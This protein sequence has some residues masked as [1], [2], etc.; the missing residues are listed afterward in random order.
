MLKDIVVVGGGPAGMM[1]AIR[2]SQLR[3]TVTLVEK[4][5]ACGLKLLLSGKGRCN[6]TNSCDLESFL[7]RYSA[8]GDFLRDSFKKFFNLEL[9]K[10]FEQRGLPLVI[11]RQGRVFPSTN[12]SDSVLD[13]LKKEMSK[14]KVKIIYNT[15]VKQVLRSDRP[16]TKPVVRGLVCSGSQVIEADKIVLAT[17]GLSYQSTGSNGDGYKMAAELGHKVV[18]P[19]PGLIALT[20]NFAYLKILQGLTLKNVGLNFIGKAVSLRT[21][22]GE[23]LFTDFGVSGPLVLTYSGKVLDAGC[24]SLQIDLKP[25]LSE[26]QTRNRIIREIKK[27]PGKA[28]KNILKELVPQK[29]AG[30]FPLLAEI[31]PDK[32]GGNITAGERDSIVSLFKK[33]PLQITGSRP[34]NEALVTRGGVSLKEINPRTMESRLVRGLF[35]AGELIDLDADTGGYNLQQAFSTGYLAGESAAVSENE[36]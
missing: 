7:K 34:I 25:G 16:Q 1:T 11:E 8:C 23:L 29:V 33:F 12:R 26:E 14:N 17:G 22:V 10:F 19:K 4:N 3:R 18:R 21:P 2:A 28:I 30:L 5:P 13:V 36:N 9:M 32:K 24:F 20:S 27:N 6:L 35:F 31:D 15:R